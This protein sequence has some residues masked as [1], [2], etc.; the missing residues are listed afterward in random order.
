MQTTNYCTH[1]VHCHTPKWWSA[2]AIDLHIRQCLSRNRGI[3]NAY[4]A[5][6]RIHSP[7]Q[8]IRSAVWWNELRKVI[9]NCFIRTTV[10]ETKPKRICLIQLVDTIEI[11]AFRKSPDKV[12]YLVRSLP[13]DREVW[14][15]TDSRRRCRS[16]WSHI[17]CRHGI[18]HTRTVFIWWAC[19]SRGRKFGEWGRTKA[20]GHRPRDRERSV[21]PG[22]LCG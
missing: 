6:R 13:S 7:Y 12:F 15:R 22:S 10:V 21:N 14:R 1:I 20:L 4:L 18:W 8:V 3:Q 11:V 17:W 5:L 2:S 9:G 16:G 19:R